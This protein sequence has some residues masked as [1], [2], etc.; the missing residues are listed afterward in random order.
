MIFDRL[1]DDDDRY[2]NRRNDEEADAC[3][4]GRWV[5]IFI[6]DEGR[7]HR[8]DVTR[9][10]EAWLLIL[11][12]SVLGDDEAVRRKAEEWRELF[13]SGTGGPG[14]GPP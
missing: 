14:M 3:F 9:D 12:A 8:N 6:D 10:D 2:I 11:F 4:P 1:R 5:G 13:P 7:E